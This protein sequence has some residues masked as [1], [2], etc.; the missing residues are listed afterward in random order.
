MRRVREQHRLRAGEVA[1]VAGEGRPRRL[2]VQAPP[3]RRVELGRA[4]QREAEGQARHLGGQHRHGAGAVDEVVVQVPRP[5]RLQ[6]PRQHPGLEQVEE[7]PQP[8]L[9]PRRPGAPGQ[10][11]GAG[12]AARRPGEQPGMGAQQAWRRL[13]GGQHGEGLGGGLGLVGA[14]LGGGRAADRAGPHVDAPRA[15]RG[16]LALDEGVRDLG[17]LARQVGDRA[18][19]G[20]GAPDL[21]RGRAQRPRLQASERRSRVA[22]CTQP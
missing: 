5:D 4:V 7:L 6:V 18:D 20:G 2:L 13:G 22:R 12:P 14:Q 11:G 17:V 8:R 1:D 21:G 15:Q 19:G 16:D 3:G 10:R 9:R